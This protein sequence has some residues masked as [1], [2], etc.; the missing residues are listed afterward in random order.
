VRSDTFAVSTAAALLLCVLQPSLALHMLTVPAGTTTAFMP[1]AGCSSS[2]AQAA[3]L[4][5]YA[6]AKYGYVAY[7][8]GGHLPTCAYSVLCH[9][10]LA[11]GLHV[12]CRLLACHLR[13]PQVHMLHICG[14]YDLHFATRSAAQL[15]CDLQLHASDVRLYVLFYGSAASHELCNMHACTR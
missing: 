13:T 1:D 4:Q 12:S 11:N 7:T 8:S 9:A 15:R 10:P 3:A 14:A 2:A 5:P 6:T